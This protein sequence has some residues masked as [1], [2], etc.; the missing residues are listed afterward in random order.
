V[1]SS[2]VRIALTGFLHR[3]LQ[4]NGTSARTISEGLQL[5]V[6]AIDHPEVIERA[7]ALWEAGFRAP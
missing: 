4:E 7:R 6:A 3:H 1:H 5:F 2:I